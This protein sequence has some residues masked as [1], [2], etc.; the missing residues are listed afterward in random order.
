MTDLILVTGTLDFD[1]AG[2]DDVIEALK[3]MM[4][5]TR[6][7]DGNVSYTFSADL[8]DQGRFHVTEKWA[9]QDAVDS[10]NASPHMSA[11]LGKLGELGSQGAS[12]SAW[13]GAT[14][15]TLF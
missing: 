1:P 7:E 2:R 9:S 14:E 4:T 12:I 11:F 8:E 5:A 3:E 13:T 6:A 15:T 10:H